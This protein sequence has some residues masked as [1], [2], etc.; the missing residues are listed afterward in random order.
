MEQVGGKCGAGALALGC[1]MMPQTLQ[2]PGKQCQPLKVTGARV[3]QSHREPLAH[4][5]LLNAS[6]VMPF[7]VPWPCPDLIAMLL[8]PLQSPWGFLLTG[9]GNATQDLLI[10]VAMQSLLAHSNVASSSTVI[11]SG[12]LGIPLDHLFDPDHLAL[13]NR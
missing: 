7:S 13:A 11:T 4:N 12:I 1:Y 9:M 5:S 8:K 2:L 6:L 10:V 3:G